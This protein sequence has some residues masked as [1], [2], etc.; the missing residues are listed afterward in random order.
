MTKIDDKAQELI[1]SGFSLGAPLGPEQDAGFGGQFRDFENATIYFHADVEAHEVHGPILDKYQ[2]VGG[3]SNRNLGFPVTDQERSADGSSDKSDF[4]FGS[5]FHVPEADPTIIHG[6]FKAK[7][8]EVGG[9]LGHL[10]LPIVNIDDDNGSCVVCQRGYLWNRPSDNTV[11]V[12][13][14]DRPLMGNPLFIRQSD[15]TNILIMQIRF[16]NHHLSGLDQLPTP[17]PIAVGSLQLLLQDR[18]HLRPVGATEPQDDVPLTLLST[19]ADPDTVDVGI[20]EIDLDHL[21]ERQLYNVCITRSDDDEVHVLSHHAVY[22]TNNEWEDFHLVHATD[23]HVARRV[24]RFAQQLADDNQTEPETIA[25][26][27]NFNDN[28]RQFIRWAN[29][30]HREGELDF[31]LATGDLIDYI[32]EEDDN[33]DGGGNFAFLKDILLGRTTSPAGV[34]AEELEL[35]IFLTLGNHDYRLNPY[36]LFWKAEIDVKELVQEVPEGLGLLVMALFL[37]GAN[38]FDVGVLSVALWLFGDAIEFKIMDRR[39]YV[40][41]NLVE[42]EAIR[43]GGEERTLSIDEAS[44]LLEIDERLLHDTSYYFRELGPVDSYTARLGKHHIVMINTRHD[45]GVTDDIRKAVYAW[46]G[47]GD[48][49]AV[50]FARGLV[51]SDGFEEAD[52]DRVLVALEETARTNQRGNVIVGMHAPPVNHRGNEYAH[53]FRETER[54]EEAEVADFVDDRG[55][56]KDSWPHNERHFFEGRELDPAIGA[57]IAEGSERFLRI[58][59]GMES[60]SPTKEVR[61][62]LCGHDHSH[63]EYRVLSRPGGGELEKFRLLMDFYT[64]NPERYYR[65]LDPEEREKK[66]LIRVRDGTFDPEGGFPVALSE[67]GILEHKLEAG[68]DGTQLDFFTMTVPPYSRTLLDETT[69]SFWSRH[70]PLILQSAPLGPTDENQRF[71]GQENEEVRDPPDPAFQ[72]V[73]HLKVQDD[74]IQRIRWVSLREIADTP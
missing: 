52:Y 69:F 68:P 1:D 7:W 73:R 49:K 22:H 4:E 55:G 53:F 6:D 37:L 70:S 58:A 19:T 23:I 25:A 16:G 38:P 35:P 20:G 12:S 17:A 31:I 47:Y 10:G 62:V 56:E 3:P 64:E 34:L 32:F 60:G 39:E 24:D 36:P 14:L 41:L 43:L 33:R 40:T 8:I 74:R 18:F 42:V 29:A 46:L 2:S 15:A 61:L 13:T 44:T 28:L 48:E 30:L 71:G 57:G 54:S 11:Q 59:T 63:A 27:N 9:E 45:A 5:I 67:D 21:K 50:N 51:N 66:V 26:Y 65:S 72:G